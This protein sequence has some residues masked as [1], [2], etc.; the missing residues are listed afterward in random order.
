MSTIPGRSTGPPTASIGSSPPD[1]PYDKTVKVDNVSSVGEVDPKDPYK[2]PTNLE[3]W[4]PNG[5]DEVL[6]IP[7]D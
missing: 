3:L 4:N 2:N 7:A 5:G 6:Q 1:A